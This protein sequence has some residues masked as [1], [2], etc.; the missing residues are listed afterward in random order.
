[1]SAKPFYACLL[2]P[3]LVAPL[4]AQDPVDGEAPVAHELPADSR[5]VPGELPGTRRFNVTFATR[6]FDL[7]EFRRA[8]YGREPVAVVD[9]IV[10][11]LRQKAR[12]EQNS[13]RLAIEKLGGVVKI[14]F[15]LINATT[16]E[17]P[18]EKIG[19]V[20][21]MP[22]VLFVNPDLPVKQLSPALIKTSTDSSHHNADAEFARGN[23]GKGLAVAIVDTGQADNTNGLGKPHQTYYPLGNK[24]LNGGG[25]GGSRLLGNFKM[26]AQP[27]NNTHLH[28]TGVAS[29]AAGG[30]WG[31]L[32][33]DHGHAPEAGIVG[34]SICQRAVSCSS[35]L[36]IE[37]AAWQKVAADKVRYNIVAGNMSYGSSPNP[38]S[39]T[40]QAIDAVALNAD[41]LP[42]TAAGN[43]GSS[44]SG[45][46]STANGL[47]VGATSASKV[48]ASFSSRGPL[49]GDTAR[50]F[51]D[52]AA[53]GVSTRM[54]R[55][56]SDNADYIASGTSM[57]S[58]QVCGAACLVKGANGSLTALQ[59]KALLL[60]STEDISTRNPGRDRN[61]YGMGYLRDDLACNQARRGSQ[62]VQS[63][64]MTNLSSASC[65][66]ISVVQ[67]RTY[68]VVIT[69]Y[70]H[71]LTSKS[72]SDLNLRILNGTSLVASSTDP[73]NLYEK[74]TFRAPLT[75]VLTVEVSAG[76]LEK[77]PLPYAVATDATLVGTCQSCQ[78]SGCNVVAAYKPYGQGCK[79]S[80]RTTSGCAVLPIAYTTRWGESN[81]YFPHGRA[82][83]RYQQVF[84]GTEVRTPANFLGVA[85]RQDD[86]T[87]GRPGGSQRYTITMGYTTRNESTLS[88]AF[89]SNFNAGNK[90]QVFSGSYN[91]P[92][93]TGL[94][95]DLTKFAVAVK[96]QTPWTYVPA[97]GR[98]ILIEFR[99]TS[100]SSVFTFMDAARSTGI[101]TTR[102]YA[103][104]SSATTAT[105]TTR[106]Y[107]LVMC[108]QLPGGPGAIPLLS[109][110]GLPKLAGSYAINLSNAVPNTVSLLLIGVSNTK[111][112]RLPL[113]LDLTLSGA[114]GCKLLASAELIAPLPVNAT[115]QS[116]FKSVVP[117]DKAFCGL[118]L[119]NQYLVIDKQAN[120][121]GLVASNA[122][123]AIHGH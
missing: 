48:M 65:H 80:G 116:T 7:K 61:S 113:P 111:W 56:T 43:S 59:I 69:W 15:W 26:A 16:I 50:F 38:L 112:G 17:I 105:G 117:G 6:S 35:T 53:N 29:I 62:A 3:L 96:F 109:N 30:K 47:A 49:S 19:E 106:N 118:N 31:T 90:R 54:A 89:D 108:F 51:P 122:G 120:T 10:A 121:L 8:V 66:R 4:P 32:G 110:V 22:N 93:L 40:Q 115:G 34:Y 95:R 2:L 21:R 101:T 67:G 71:V 98:N 75:G 5:A 20:R 85:L 123:Q 73:R 82:N 24:T 28:G 33:A 99:N 87:R 52:I 78:P 39:V 41:V 11:R 9:A 64:N 114:P 57:A 63:C 12:E 103:F 76:S 13:F 27:P 92:S 74:V 58:P 14:H 91:I 55:R 44:T 36:S 81:N 23:R 45:S 1:M 42:V 94:N 46:S 68:H 83:M 72:W 100:S 88:T 60:A 25:I 77:T 79:G 84:R 86:L 18:P 107:G 37:A 119:F 104:S 70:R 97:I 102:M